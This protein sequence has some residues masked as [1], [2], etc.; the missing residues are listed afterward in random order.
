MSAREEAARE[1]RS[2]LDRVGMLA[3]ALHA[4]GDRDGARLLV[5]GAST[6]CATWLRQ[7]EPPLRAVARAL[8]DL[9]ATVEGLDPA[10]QPSA[11]ND[12][13]SYVMARGRAAFTAATGGE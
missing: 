5:G 7:Y 6:A 4:S 2:L 8:R 3:G 12:A 9:D 13:L 10:A 1:T 11:W